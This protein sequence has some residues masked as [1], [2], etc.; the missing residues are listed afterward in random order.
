MAELIN[1]KAIF[2]G[3]DYLH[4]LNLITDALGTPS[5]EDMTHITHSEAL[6]YLKTLPKKKPIP[7]RVLFPKATPEEIDLLSKMLVFNPA[8]RISAADALA[9][10][11]LS[12][13]HD[14]SDEPVSNLTFQFEY[15][16][17]EITEPMLRKLMYEEACAYHSDMSPF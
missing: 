11:Y 7:L 4:Q 12:G 2:P 10:P 5:E 15:D 13:L 1:R 8:K 3:K 17:K 9:H 14:L 16:D 6:R